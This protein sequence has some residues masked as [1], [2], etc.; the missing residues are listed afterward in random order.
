MSNLTT[1]SSYEVTI[2]SSTTTSGAINIQ[3]ADGKYIGNSGSKNTAKL[4]ATASVNT[5]YTPTIGDNNVVTLT[6]PK[7]V[8]ETYTTLQYNT[9]SPR[10]ANYGG[11]QKNV[12]I[13]KKK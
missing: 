5:D 11:T 2:S 8:S 13:Y 12:V 1:S 10:F 7:E 6:S 9:G 3:M 4:Y